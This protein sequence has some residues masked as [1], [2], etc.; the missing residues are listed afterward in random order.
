MTRVCLDGHGERWSRSRS[1]KEA[2]I[3]Y[4]GGG[5]GEP[6]GAMNW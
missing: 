4:A 5:V 3:A 6:A 1:R 2:A